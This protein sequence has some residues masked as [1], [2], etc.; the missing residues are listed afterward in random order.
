MPWVI[1]KWAQTRTGQ[2]L[3][4]E[5]HA[6]GHWISGQAARHDVLVLR[7]RVDAIVT[8]I[9]T[10]LA[11]DPRLTVRPP[12]DLARPPLRVVLDSELRTQSTARLFH[13]AGPD[14]AAGPVRIIARAGFNPNRYRALTAAGARIDAL[15]PGDAGHSSL[16]E[17]LALLWNEGVRRVLLEAGPTL[18]TAAFEHEFVDQVRVY[19][20]AINGGRG[21]SLAGRLV[22]ERLTQIERSEV[23]EDARLDAFLRAV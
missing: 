3:P 15:H 10:V 12:G 4:P 18:L 6:D 7:G 20:G 14:E 17:A 8:G 21:P 23:G 2:L 11:D 9:G 5:G 22:P 1:A 19:T 16:R 13:P